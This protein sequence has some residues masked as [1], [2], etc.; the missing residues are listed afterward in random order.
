MIID[1]IRI[2]K[3]WHFEDGTVLPV[4]SGGSDAVTTDPPPPPAAT[5][6]PRGPNGQFVSPQ[7]P[8]STPGAVTVGGQPV[9]TFTAEDIERAR[10][11][12]KDKLY[13]TIQS[14]QERVETLAAA[15]E[16]RQRLAD[17]AEAARQRA[18]EAERQAEM[19]ATERVTE[20]ENRFAAQL[21]ELQAER[22]R[23]KA[24]FEQEQRLA[25]LRQYA[26]QQL[27]AN[28]EQIMPALRD[29]VLDQMGNPVGVVQGTQEEVDRQVA[30]AIQKSGEILA[31]VQEAQAP[32]GFPQQV[33]P[34]QQY[35]GASITA[36]VHGPLDTQTGQQTITPE[37]IRDMPMSEYA[38]QR[39]RLLGGASRQVSERGL[40]G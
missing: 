2:G 20:V 24:L 39:E 18:E 38:A 17:E 1:P 26:Q 11:Q 14:L 15:E 10:Q 22:E 29:L 34:P 27:A 9:T 4:V 7:A 31:S 21:A 37:Q 3:H 36:P 32:A 28:A 12:E 30:L 25:N 35:Q 6:P 8:A 33:P 13:P 40:Y 23:D 19:S 5:E 16:E